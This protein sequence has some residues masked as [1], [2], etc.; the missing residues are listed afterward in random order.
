MFTTPVGTPAW[1]QISANTMAVSD[2]YSAGF[3]TTVLPIASAGAIFHASISSGKFH[4]MICPQTPKAC[5]VGQFVVH[6]LRH[7][8]VIIEMPDRQRHIDVAAFAD[9]FAVIQRFHHGKQAGVFLQQ[10]GNSIKI[11]ARFG[12]SISAHLRLCR[13]GGCHGGIHIGGAW[14]SV[15]STSPVAGLR[16]SNPCRGRKGPLMKWP[17]RSP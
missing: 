11:R 10:T 13:A 8:R 2:V 6:Q 12:P 14:V 7:A 1:R 9:R 5:A 3:S 17:N 15:A 16:L 4:G